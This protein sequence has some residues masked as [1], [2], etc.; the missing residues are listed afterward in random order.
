MPEAEPQLATH[1]VTP[2]STT[3]VPPPPMPS[4]TPVTEYE[5]SEA[6]ASYRID[7]VPPSQFVQSAPEAEAAGTQTD[8][9]QTPA[10]HIGEAPIAEDQ[11]IDVDSFPNL[12]PEMMQEPLHHREAEAV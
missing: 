4:E 7:P 11:P 10:E 6:S 8:E 3:F 1:Q 2:L 12:I 9:E 5:P